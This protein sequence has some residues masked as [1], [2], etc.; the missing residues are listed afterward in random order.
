[1]INPLGKFHEK[2]IEFFL[3]F[4]F[5]IFS[6]LRLILFLKELLVQSSDIHRNGFLYFLL[7]ILQ[8]LQLNFFV[9]LVR[10]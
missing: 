1:M 7:F 5:S 4:V 8:V 6:I 9:L 10:H 3:K 2:K